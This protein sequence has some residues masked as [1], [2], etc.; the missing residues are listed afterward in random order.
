MSL[1][2][3]IGTGVGR[4]RNEEERDK[5]YEKMTRGLRPAEKRA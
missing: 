1:M 3:E 5:F 2:T 4:F